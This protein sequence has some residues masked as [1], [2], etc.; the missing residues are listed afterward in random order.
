[1]LFVDILVGFGHCVEC[2]IIYSDF[3][4]GPRPYTHS[5]RNVSHK[6]NGE[7]VPFRSCVAQKAHPGFLRA[8]VNTLYGLQVPKGAPHRLKI[9][10]KYIQ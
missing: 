1:M 4:I 8:Q 3:Y 2:I 10:F 7:G 6:D 5:T 9:H